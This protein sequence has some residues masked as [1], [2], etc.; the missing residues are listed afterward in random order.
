MCSLRTTK[1]V[2][3]AISCFLTSG[4]LF[5]ADEPAIPSDLSGYRFVSALVVNDPQSP[6]FGFHHF[7][8]NDEARGVLADGGPYPEGAVFVGLVY[9]VQADGRNIDEGQG[10][11]VTLME[12]VSGAKETGGWR[13][14][15]FD[16]AG[17]PVQ[18]DQAKDCFACHTQVKDRDYVF[19]RPLG[20]GA[21]NSLK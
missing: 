21:L 3:V 14:A 5:A 19:S 2:A 11:A 16:A 15:Q 9:Q 4:S 17:S 8:A 18:I 12:K 7:Y 10:A 20:I 13:F 6:L 1:L